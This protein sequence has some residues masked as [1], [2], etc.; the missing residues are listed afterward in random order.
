MEIVWEEQAIRSL[1]RLTDG[2]QGYV[3]LIYDSED[4]GCGDDGMS[5]LW[6]ISEPEGNEIVVETNIGEMLVDKDKLVYMDDE[7][8]IAWVEDFNSFRLKNKNGIINPFMH[9][10]NWVKQASYILANKGVYPPV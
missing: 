9:F 2:K 10:Y 5:T 8:T 4:C 7:M 6:F 3:K 1:K